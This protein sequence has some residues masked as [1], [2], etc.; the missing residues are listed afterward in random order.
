M[1]INP[2]AATENQGIIFP[3]N[4]WKACGDEYLNQFIPMVV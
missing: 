3:A 1:P 4:G 2:I